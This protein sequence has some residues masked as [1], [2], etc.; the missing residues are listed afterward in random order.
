METN[1]LLDTAVTTLAS[2]AESTRPD[3]LDQ[4]TPCAKWRVRDL[5]NHVVGGGHAFGDDGCVSESGLIIGTYL[6]GLF[7]NKNFRNA[8]L[9]YLY[10]RRGMIFSSEE[11]GDSIEEL[12]R[13]VEKNVNM[14]LIYRRIEDE[15]A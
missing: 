15:A 6:H 3:Q 14:E 4:P 10:K 9:G 1:E 5:L 11:E 12:A 7:E 8:F 13:F 2:L